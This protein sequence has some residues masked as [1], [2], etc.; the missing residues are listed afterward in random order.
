MARWLGWLSVSCLYVLSLSTGHL[1]PEPGWCRSRE[2]AWAGVGS[3]SEL[4]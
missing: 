2:L 4:P 3:W 1:V